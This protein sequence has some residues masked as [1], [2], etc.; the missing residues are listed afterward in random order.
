MLKIK[1][2]QNKIKKYNDFELNTMTY[3]QALK[4][5]K[6]AFYQY[7]ISLIKRK[8]PVIFSFFPITD[9]NSIII[10][11]DLF[12]L[13]FSF[14]YFF[15]AL[16]FDEKVIHKIYEDE[17][18]YN[19]VYLV[20]FVMYSF[21]LSHFLFITVKYF[22]L[23]EKNISQIKID[24]ND[25]NTDKIKRKIIIKYFLFFIISIA[26]LSFL[27]YYLSSFGAVY[28]NTQTYLLKNTMISFGISFLYPFIINIIPVIIRIYSL[29]KKK[30]SMYKIGFIIQYI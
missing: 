2:E 17:G 13:S 12:Y 14:Y 4:I 28:Q 27:W 10:K 6:R 18:I 1:D 11:F 3:N 22:S 23:S 24:K 26:F 19:F 8:H 7:Y 5:D 30:E 20:P 9:Y 15:N 25:D 21:I 29:N 16:F